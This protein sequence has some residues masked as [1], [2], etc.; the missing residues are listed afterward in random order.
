M[1]PTAPI[2]EVRPPDGRWDT[3]YHAPVLV[4]EVLETLAGA[5]LVLDCTLGGGGHSAAILES[6]ASVIGLDRDP[7]AVEA[8]CD[9]LRASERGSTFKAY[10]GNY[11]GIQELPDV[12][13]KTFDGIL[14]DLG[15]S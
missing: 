10:V 3:A 5:R 2:A 6:G 8:A 4:D 1:S 9:R 13:D 14:L 7:T 11:A 15:V 12:R